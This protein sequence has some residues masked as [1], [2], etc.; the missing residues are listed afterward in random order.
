MLHPLK[1][2]REKY[3]VEY[4]PD[5]DFS[6]YA[7]LLQSKWREENGYPIGDEKKYGNYIDL[8][9]AKETKVN[10]LT[11]NIRKLV[12]QEIANG[13]KKIIDS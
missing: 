9:F 4:A 1:S 11:E 12:S 6:A 5:S 7:R 13:K 2:E 10:F 3:K 8:D